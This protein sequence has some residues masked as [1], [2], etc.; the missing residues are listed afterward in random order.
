[1]AEA[2]ALKRPIVTTDFTGAKEQ[3]IDEKTGLIVGV[4][5]GQIYRAVKELIR[6]PDLCKEFSTN[7]ANEVPDNTVEMEKIYDLV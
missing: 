2:R 7:L 4:H 6:N 3:I 1:M 5:E